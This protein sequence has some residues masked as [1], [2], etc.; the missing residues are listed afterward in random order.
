M[1]RSVRFPPDRPHQTLSRGTRCPLSGPLPRLA[2]PALLALLAACD[3]G[4]GSGADRLSPSEVQGVYQVCAL[5]FAPE[6]P[7]LP[8]ADLL[9]TVVHTSPPA[10][11]PIPTLT[12]SPSGQFEL[13][14]TRRS[15]AFLQQVRGDVGYRS[16]AVLIG[17]P[18]QDAS[19]IVRET[20]LPGSNLV[21]EFDASPRR[22]STAG[23]SFYSVRRA[24]YARAAGI[25][26]TGLQERITG[27]LTATFSVSGC[28]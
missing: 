14:Y 18:D 13:V 7:A 17:F 5:R 20:L 6:Q 23:T 15:D 16:S 12:L 21:L 11:K 4:G 22:L 9:Q 19:A 27:M 3:G 2:A 25:P 1:P 24:D 28:P 10:G 8:T 26:E